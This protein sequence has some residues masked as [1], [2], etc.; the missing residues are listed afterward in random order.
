VTGLERIPGVVKLMLVAR[1]EAREKLQLCEAALQEVLA[2]RA[3][4]TFTIE[5]VPF[6]VCGRVGKLYVRRLTGPEETERLR[7]AWRR[8]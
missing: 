3:G 8:E 5:G 7:E 4:T 1:N 2:P 6:K